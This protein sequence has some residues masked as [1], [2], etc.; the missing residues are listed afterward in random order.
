MIILT[1]IIN[2]PCSEKLNYEAASFI[3]V[4]VLQ[5]RIDDDILT[6]AGP[7]ISFLFRHFEETP[8]A[9]AATA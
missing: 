3:K 7:Y 9:A 2:P 4:T 5:G 1:K 6:S 8:A